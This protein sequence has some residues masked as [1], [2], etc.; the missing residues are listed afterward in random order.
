[1]KG[2]DVKI[3]FDVVVEGI[4]PEVSRFIVYPGKACDETETF[5]VSG[6]K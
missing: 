6:S 4:A 2:G 3:S 5:I 1:M